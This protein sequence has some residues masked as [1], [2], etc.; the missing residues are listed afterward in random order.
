MTSLLKRVGLFCLFGLLIDTIL[1][2]FGYFLAVTGG[3]EPSLALFFPWAALFQYLN[4]IEGDGQ[5]LFCALIP[6][7]LYA[8]VLAVFWTKKD[9]LHYVACAVT[10]LHFLATALSVYA[11]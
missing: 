3:S 2:G 4:L 8:I 7:P 11:K 1:F 10:L 5:W 9:K 6:M